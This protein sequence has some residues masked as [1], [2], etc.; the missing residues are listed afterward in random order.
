[1]TIYS[2]GDSGQDLKIFLKNH[3]KVVR[4]TFFDNV[5]SGDSGHEYNLCYN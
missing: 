1:M 3:A 4:I 5:L 2:S